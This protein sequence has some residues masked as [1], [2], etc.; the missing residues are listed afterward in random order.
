MPTQIPPL[1]CASVGMTIVSEALSKNISRK[2][3]RN[4]R[5]L[6]CARDDKGESDASIESSCWTGASVVEDLRFPSSCWSFN[7]QSIAKPYRLF[8]IVD[9][10]ESSETVLN[11]V[12]VGTPQQTNRTVVDPVAAYRSRDPVRRKHQSRCPKVPKQ[13]KV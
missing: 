6:G 5:S 8:Q 11:T 1:R 13:K 3:P 4:C 10:P 2:G 9:A 12:L 7:S